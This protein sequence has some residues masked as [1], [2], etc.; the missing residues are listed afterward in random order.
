MDGIKWIKL[1]VDFIHS[2]KVKYLR[3]Q[4]GGDTMALLWVQLLCRA[5]E[6]N[7]RGRVYVAPGVPYTMAAL[8]KEF[9]VSKKRVGEA[10]ALFEQLG[11]LRLEEGVLVI[12]NWCEHQNVEGMERV[13]ESSKRTALADEDT[14]RESARARSRESSRRYRDRQK[15]AADADQMTMDE[16]LGDDH[17]DMTVTVPVTDGDGHGDTLVTVKNGHGDTM[18][19]AKSGHGDS[20]DRDNRVRE[21]IEKREEEPDIQKALGIDDEYKVSSRARAKTASL[22]KD[23]I[24]ARGL[25]AGHLPKL[26]DA[27]EEALGHGHTPA[28]VM[29]Q[30]VDSCGDWARFA[31]VLM[32]PKR[33][34]AT[35]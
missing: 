23:A 21:E 9:G 31:S 33:E 32:I 6:V 19:T 22:L 8:A 17:C 27:I 11:M 20:P 30:A 16:C 25:L 14:T 15:S 34:W 7:D 12:A 10:I 3:T 28:D 18:V 2:S 5:G 29:K 4:R 24:L 35:E 1:S 13:R 26:F